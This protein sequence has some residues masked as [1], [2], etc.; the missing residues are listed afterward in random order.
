L[1]AVIRRSLY[2]DTIASSITIPT[3]NVRGQH[4]DERHRRL[5]VEPRF[6]A[7]LFRAVFRIANNATRA[8]TTSGN[9]I[10]IQGL[11]CLYTDLFLSQSQ[12]RPSLIELRLRLLDSEF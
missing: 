4:S 2:L 10:R 8:L 7:R 11:T 5:A 1:L 12:G 6:S 3:I 9:L